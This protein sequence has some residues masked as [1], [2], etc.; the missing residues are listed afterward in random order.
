MRGASQV[1]DGEKNLER[2][3]RLGDAVQ[4]CP[5]ALTAGKRGW[6]GPCD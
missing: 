1:E 2:L 6:R 4:K 3:P 5:E